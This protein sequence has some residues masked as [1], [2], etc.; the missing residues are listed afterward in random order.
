[1]TDLMGPLPS[2][3]QLQSNY[4]LTNN[5]IEIPGESQVISPSYHE[6]QPA[7]VSTHTEN[8]DEKDM[9]IGNDFEKSESD[10]ENEEGTQHLWNEETFK[11]AAQ[12]FAGILPYKGKG[13][14]IIFFPKLGDGAGKIST[15][16]IQPFFFVYY[17]DEKRR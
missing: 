12:S 2:H 15:I 3:Y 8:T 4:L 10:D 1:M 5:T 6:L 7:S 16:I 17:S 13:L 9:I 14:W 11:G